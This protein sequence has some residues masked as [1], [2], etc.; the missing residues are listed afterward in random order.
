MLST[1]AAKALALT[2]GCDVASE[3]PK[4][5]KDCS[6]A[7]GG[8]AVGGATVGGAAVELTVVG[9][10]PAGSPVVDIVRYLSSLSYR[11]KALF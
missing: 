4:S 3:P 11:R 8:A 7:A 9:T 1:C 6:A 5:I 10:V 2:R